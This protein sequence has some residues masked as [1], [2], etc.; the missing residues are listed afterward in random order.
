V[1]RV[2]GGGAHP[3]PRA[4]AGPSCTSTA[5][6]GSRARSPPAAGRWPG[7]RWAAR[8]GFASRLSSLSPGGGQPTTRA[9]FEGDVPP[10][11]D[12]AGGAGRRLRRGAHR[13][14]RPGRGRGARGQPHPG[15]GG[16]LFR[17]RPRRRG[18]G[19]RRC[20][21]E[22]STASRAHHR[23]RRQRHRGPVLDRRGAAGRL[24][25]RRHLRRAGAPSSPGCASPRA[26]RCRRTSS[27]GRGP[28]PGAWWTPRAGRCRGLH[29][30]APRR[31]RGAR[32]PRGASR[33]DGTF[34]LHGLTGSRFAVSATA[35]QGRAERAGVEP[36]TRDLV[37][38]L[39]SGGLE[40][41]VVG[42]RGEPV[43]RLRGLRGA[44]PRSTAGRPRSQ[45]LPLALGDF[46]MSLSPG[47]Y[48]LRVG[49]PRVLL[50]GLPGVEVR[51]GAPGPQCEGSS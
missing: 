32:V 19:G 47:R 12:G 50:R 36:G 40:G 41:K 42:D 25:R 13:G 4:H 7:P 14:V 20:K 26:P 23:R 1:P 38:A 2:S 46:K 43:H 35:S 24:P 21:V 11:A 22:A 45:A 28:S 31:Q 3:R 15:Q 34:E 48:G 37:L 51:E 8:Y 5:P 16:T 44:A 33:S 49:A 18:G 9:P 10:G 27:W 30:R 6:A 29:R 39:V 17:L